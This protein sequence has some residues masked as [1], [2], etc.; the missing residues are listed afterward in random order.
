[1]GELSYELLFLEAYVKNIFA[2]ERFPEKGWGKNL[3][4]RVF[5]GRVVPLKLEWRKR[6]EAAKAREQIPEG[7][8]PS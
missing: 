7:A 5:L 8:W 4:V 2:V 3:C 6:K 1:M